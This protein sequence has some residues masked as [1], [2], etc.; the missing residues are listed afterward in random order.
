MKSAHDR[1]SRLKHSVDTSL[2]EMMEKCHE[3]EPFRLKSLMEMKKESLGLEAFNNSEI[4][5]K[6]LMGDLDQGEQIW[7]YHDAVTN[8]WN[9]VARTNLYTRVFLYGYFVTF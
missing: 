5:K 4:K 3:P 6:M 8:P 1:C 7:V 9:L 2:V